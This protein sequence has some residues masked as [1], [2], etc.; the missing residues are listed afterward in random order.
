[1]NSINITG[2]FTKDPV[3]S[4]TNTSQKSVLNFDIAVDSGSDDPFFFPVQAWE[5]LAE[6]TAQYCKKG[7]LVGVTGRLIQE[8]YNDKEGKER[9]ATKIL[10]SSIDF[11]SQPQGNGGN[12]NQGGQQAQSNDPFAGSSAPTVDPFA[13]IGMGNQQPAND[14]FAGLNSQPSTNDPFSNPVAGNGASADPFAGLGFLKPS[15]DPF[16]K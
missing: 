16:G 8:K 3:L 10:A 11:L 12:Q 13:G 5:K 1:M 15:N 6:N 7:T 14:P 2:R 9:I 4:K